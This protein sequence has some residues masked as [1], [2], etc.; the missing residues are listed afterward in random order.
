MKKLLFLALLGLSF[1]VKA[2]DNSK[3]AKDTV[4]ATT[5]TINQ[6]RQVLAVLDAN[7]DSKKVSKELIDFLVKETKIVQPA[8]D[9]KK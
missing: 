7:I 2:Q 6:F 1:S 9:P 3:A 5:M 8:T 4:V